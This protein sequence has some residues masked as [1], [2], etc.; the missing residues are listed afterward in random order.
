M[1]QEIKHTEER[2]RQYLVLDPELILQNTAGNEISLFDLWTVLS[3]KRIL[4]FGILAASLVIS[5]ATAFL[6]TPVY[7]ATIHFAPPLKKDIDILNI[8]EFSSAYTTDDA[9]KAFQNNF[10]ARNNL[11]DFFVEKQLYKAYLDENGYADEDIDKTFDTEFLENVTLH[12]PKPGGDQAFMNATLDWDDATEGAAL[13]NEYSQTVSSIT[14]EKYVDE[15]SNKLLL[16]KERL[17]GQITLLRES[18]QREKEYRLIELD[19]NISIAK[20]LGIKRRDDLLD[21]KRSDVFV[22]ASG[23]QPLYY[24]GYEALEAE[25]RSLQIRKSNDPFTPGLNEKLKELEYLNAIKI[26]PGQISVVRVTQQAKAL[27]E[28]VK[29]RKKMI[30]ILGSVLGLFLGILV[31]FVAYAVEGRR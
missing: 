29:P 30:V 18:A 14:V 7:Q 1:S 12:Q 16:D 17:Q 24:Q 9:Y 8:P 19:E 4:I 15:L 5:A 10:I 23:K 2:T 6:L 20:E 13:L 3:K 11:W 27:N 28:P 21:Q 26:P 31:A 25:K 22:D